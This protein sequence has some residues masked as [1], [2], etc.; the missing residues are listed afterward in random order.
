MLSNTTKIKITLYEGQK[1]LEVS[2]NFALQEKWGDKAW[3]MAE[4]VLAGR[5]VAYL[6]EELRSWSPEVPKKLLFGPFDN[7][8]KD[9]DNYSMIDVAKTLEIKLSTKAMQGLYWVLLAATHPA[10][11]LLLSSGVQADTIWPV[12]IKARLVGKLEKELGMKL[13]EPV[14]EFDP[15][16]PSVQL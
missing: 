11:P 10:S 13:E 4:R 1:L 12:A 2:A 9:G 3:N 15:P 7:W 14:M 16:D 6:Y 8:K 5:A